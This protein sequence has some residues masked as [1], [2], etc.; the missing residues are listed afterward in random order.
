MCEFLFFILLITVAGFLIYLAN[1]DGKSKSVEICSEKS[2]N[3]LGKK[4]NKLLKELSFSDMYTFENFEVVQRFGGVN[5]H[6][7]F[8][9]T[10]IS[11]GSNF[12]SN[13]VDKLEWME[14]KY[15]SVVLWRKAG[16]WV[17]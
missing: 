2:E 10:D 13:I 9:I 16:E 8:E 3:A 6:S 12:D 1:K 7:S 14:S 15:D 11:D 5:F 4:L 17:K